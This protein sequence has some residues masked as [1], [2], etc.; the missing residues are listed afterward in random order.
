MLA[1]FGRPRWM[2]KEVIARLDDHVRVN[3]RRAAKASA[4]SDGVSVADLQAGLLPQLLR[5]FL[6][7]LLGT[8]KPS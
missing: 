2:V 4:D 1:D 3:G 7:L 6:G 5:P 8:P